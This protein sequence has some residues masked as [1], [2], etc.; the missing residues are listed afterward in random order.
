MAACTEHVPNPSDDHKQMVFD[1]NGD[2][3]HEEYL[4]I[5]GTG[6][7]NQPHISN[8]NLEASCSL[9]DRLFHWE[10]NG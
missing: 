4:N 8:K 7:R 5:P 1:Q 2:V 3:I 9:G 6:R 10:M